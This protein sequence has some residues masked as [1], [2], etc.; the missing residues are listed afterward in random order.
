MCHEV[1]GLV[2]RVGVLIVI[3]IILTFFFNEEPVD[4]LD[5]SALVVLL[6]L[7]SF[8]IDHSIKTLLEI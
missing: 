8:L 1:V 5:K 4:K 6:I 2:L 3:L 7:L